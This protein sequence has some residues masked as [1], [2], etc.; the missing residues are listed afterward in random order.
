MS[1]SLHD[2]L[3][4]TEYTDRGSGPEWVPSGA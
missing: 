1:D 3:L 2:Q 4:S